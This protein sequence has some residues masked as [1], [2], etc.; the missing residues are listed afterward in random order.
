[1]ITLVESKNGFYVPKECYTP[2]KFILPSKLEPILNDLLY[3][4]E[5]YTDEE[6]IEINELLCTEFEMELATNKKSY[7]E[8]NKAGF[9]YLLKC[10]DKYKIGYSKN[11]EHRIKQLDTRPFKIELVLKIYSENAYDIEQ[12]LHKKL[13]LH[14]A[15]GEWYNSSLQKVNIVSLIKEIAEGLQCDIQF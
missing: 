2:N 9:I 12:E 5:H 10:S 3:Y 6:I 13:E 14:K 8:R 4:C 11:V 1:M 7:K 15:D